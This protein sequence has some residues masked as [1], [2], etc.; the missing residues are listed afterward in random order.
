MMYEEARLPLSPMQ[1]NI[2][3]A[4]DQPPP[5]LLELPAAIKGENLDAEAS[6]IVSRAGSAVP[7]EES[8]S[9]F[10]YFTDV[11]SSGGGGRSPS[12]VLFSKRGEA[13]LEADLGDGSTPEMTPEASLRSD[14]PQCASSVDELETD[15]QLVEDS[16]TGTST[17]VVSTTLQVTATTL[18]VDKDAESAIHALLALQREPS[19]TN[20]RSRGSSPEPFR[21]RPSSP[22]LGRQGAIHK[23]GSEASRFFCKFPRCGKA[24]ASTD[25]VRKHCRQRHLDWLRRQGHGCP[26]LYC[27]WED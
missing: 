7:T 9:P 22:S 26:A 12:S 18:Q 13:D 10:A 21:R 4:N 27:R 16:S 17:D 2:M 8:C 23:G 25:A 15:D 1:D 19:P 3:P 5:P 14:S 24:Y 20:G 6:G 11:K